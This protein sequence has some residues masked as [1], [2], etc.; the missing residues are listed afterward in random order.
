MILSDVTLREGD[1]MPGRNYSVEQKVTAGKKLDELGLAFIQPGF[2][3]TGEKDRTAIRRLASTT[4]AQIVALARAVEDDIE[5]AA[6]AEADVAEVII[7]ISDL[8]L[9]YS[10]KKPRNEVLRLAREAIDLATEHGLVPHLTL[11]DAFRTEPEHLSE[12]ATRFNDVDFVTLADTV[13]ARTPVSVRDLLSTLQEDVALSTIG[14]HFHDDMGVATANALAA[15]EVGVGKADV[16]VAS[17]GERAGNAA[18]EE[19]V[20]SGVVEH[21]VSF[22]VTE[23]KLIPTC[24]SVLDILEEADA[25]GPRKAILGSEVT[26]HESGIHTAAMLHEPSVFEPFNPYVF[27]GH[28]ELLFGRGTGASGAS[29]LLSRANI[30]PTDQ[31]VERFL[32]LLAEK[33]PMNEAE[34]LALARSS[35]EE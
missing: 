24:R 20:A 22:G 21:D 7:P 31:R 30:E 14:V 34:A 29:T 13:G 2:P 17:L 9:E 19:V 6:V 15:Y 33:G 32:A 26:E 12:V 23:D 18:L 11:I 1:Q 25:A 28:R 16:S 35:M 4:D 5:A 27:G 3:I 10:L 8:Q